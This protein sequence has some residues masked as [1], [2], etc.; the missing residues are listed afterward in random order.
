MM[1]IPRVGQEVL[2]SFLDGNPDQP[3][4]VGRVYNQKNPVP[5]EPPERKTR[6]TW[7]SDS[8]LGSNGFNEIMFEDLKGQEL[9]WEQAQKDRVRLVKNDETATIVHDRELLVKNDLEERRPAKLSPM[10]E[11]LIDVLEVKVKHAEDALA[12]AISEVFSLSMLLLA[13]NF[14]PNHVG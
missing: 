13:E 5:Y 14:S 7:K 4:I 1:H 11:K 3:V 2:V 6:S 9:V 10:P 8:S 12:K